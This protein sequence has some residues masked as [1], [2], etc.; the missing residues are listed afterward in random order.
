M[1]FSEYSK[2]SDKLLDMWESLE[3]IERKCEKLA[4]DQ[5]TREPR[6]RNETKRC[7]V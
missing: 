1:I 6:R 4:D 7:S 5:R 2:N 3:F